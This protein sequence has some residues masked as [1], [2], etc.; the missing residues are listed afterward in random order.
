[1][2]TQLEPAVDRV[3]AWIDDA[4][5]E[6]VVVLTGAGISTDSGIPDFRGP[7]GVWTKNPKA[8]KQ[9]SIQH[10]L[11]DPEVRRASWQ[12][13]L[14]S[15]AW[16]AVP[17]AGHRAVVTLERRGKLHTLVT[18]NIDELHQKAGTH[19]SRVVEV[20][21]T[22]R[23]V[24]CLACG[25]RAPMELALERVRAGEDDP[26]C[27]TCGGILKSAT[28]SFGQALVAA[29]LQRAEQAARAAHLLLAV[30]TTLAVYPVAEI[31]PI[32]AMSG[33]RV[34]I[35]NAEPTAMDDLADVVL[36]GAIGD[37]LPA[38]VGGVGGVAGKPTD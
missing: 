10:Y 37:L 16:T 19:P 1:V 20:H 27:R 3:R 33:A 5:D 38:V 21:G 8:E 32:A 23:K 26:P 22:M 14:H 31:V 29:D 35:V 11:A 36:R 2:A 12:M 17:N 15:P 6:S 18:Q 30:G 24:V 7:N 9:A 4:P 28:I 25:E 34:V 13:R